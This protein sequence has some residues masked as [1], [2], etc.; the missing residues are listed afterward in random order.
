MCDLPNG[1][2]RL[3]YDVRSEMSDGGRAAVHISRR[4]RRESAEAAPELY[5]SLLEYN[6]L[7][8]HPSARA[9]VAEK[10]DKS[11]E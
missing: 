2:G 6:R 8:T 11:E 4:I 10:I 5:P 1:L 3:S 7:S 9:L